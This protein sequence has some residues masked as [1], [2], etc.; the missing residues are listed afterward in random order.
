M[1]VDRCSRRLV[2][3]GGNGIDYLYGGSGDDTY[4]LRSGMTQPMSMLRC[5][6]HR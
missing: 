3:D 6:L 5:I 4:I 1:V 2:L